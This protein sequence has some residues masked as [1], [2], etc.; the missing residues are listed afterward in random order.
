VGWRDRDYARLREEE[1]EALYGFRTPSRPR[2]ISARQVVW[3]SVGVLGVAVL[4]FG[5][6]Q[7]QHPARPLPQPSVLYGQPVA[8]Q[9]GACTDLQLDASGQWACGEY[10]GTIEHLPVVTPAPYDGPCTHLV[11]DQSRGRWV[12]LSSRQT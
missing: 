2:T 12:C 10:T 5:L 9:E 6:T 1:L 4:G 11:A 8:G 7:R 3:T